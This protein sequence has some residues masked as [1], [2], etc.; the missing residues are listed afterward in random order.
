MQKKR[1][2]LWICI[3]CICIFVILLSIV[4]HFAFNLKNV[5]VEFQSR[6]SQ[7]NT[8]LETGVQEEISNY[9]DFG[10]NII[11]MNFDENILEIEKNIPYVKINQIVKFFPN[12]IRV[13]ISERIPKYKIKSE[14]NSN[15][16][17]ILD[18]DFKVL[19][20]IDEINIENAKTDLEDVIEIENVSLTVSEGEF[21]TNLP[22][23]NADLNNIVAG[24]YGRTEDFS[25][26]KSISISGTEEKVYTLTMKNDAREDGSGCRIL[27]SGEN[28]LTTKIFVAISTFEAELSSSDFLNEPSTTI[29]VFYSNGEYKAIKNTV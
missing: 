12:T 18:E 21:I 23:L 27:V 25:I 28:D 9:F 3:S 20:I 13:Y 8:R 26:V 19:E 22:D 11:L 14:T 29:T 10:N 1:K 7:E 15:E 4:V 24:V 5:D 2:V 6:L 17:I 16:W